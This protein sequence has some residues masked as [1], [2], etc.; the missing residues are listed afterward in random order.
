MPDSPERILEL[1]PTEDEE[2]FA[3]LTYIE[4]LS[5]ADRINTMMKLGMSGPRETILDAG[6]KYAED[7]NPEIASLANV[8]LA[9]IPANDFLASKDPMHL[10]LFKEQFDSRHERIL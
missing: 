2:L 5:V 9:T 4:S 8:A 6:N 7:T 3:T 10:E 1:E